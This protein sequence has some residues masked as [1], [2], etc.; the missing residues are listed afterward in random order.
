MKHPIL[1]LTRDRPDQF[2]DMIESIRRSTDPDTYRLIICDNA[3]TCPKMLDYLDLLEQQD[4]RVIHNKANLLFEGLNPGLA[5]VDAD[6][7]L[8]SDPDIILN[9]KIPFHWILR[10]KEVLQNVMMPKIG[11][12]LD[13]NFE[14]DNEFTRRIT[15]GES[16][17]WKD[18]ISLPGIS[19]PC[20]LGGIDTTMAM[21]R[22]DTFRYWDET[23]VFD[24]EH[25][26]NSDEQIRQ[27]EYSEKYYIPV[28]RVAG[29]YT[30]TH[31]GWD[32]SGKYAEDQAYYLK[33]CNM[34]AAS[35]IKGWFAGE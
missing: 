8:I 2:R 1:I 14:E 3:S 33:T 4:C 6:Y 15:E 19:D 22:R 27:S 9:P 24:K 28:S 35:T 18:T 13:I 21:Y 16:Q 25:G 10:L 11:L 30:A 34:N 7:F 29:A 5:E 26:V 31:T 20:Y 23:M 12:A 32:R 17:Y